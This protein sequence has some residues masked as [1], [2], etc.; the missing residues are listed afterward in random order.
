MM[1]EHQVAVFTA[2]M[3]SPTL[4]VAEEFTGIAGLYLFHPL[5]IA[6]IFETIFP[7]LPEVVVVDIA[8]VI[9]A[10]YTSAR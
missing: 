1:T 6:I 7:H 5:A 8:L 9:L 3:H 2:E 10:T 4:A